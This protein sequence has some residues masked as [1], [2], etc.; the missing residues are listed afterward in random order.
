MA[1]PAA[2]FT[3]VNYTVKD[4]SA[5]AGELTGRGWV[6]QRYEGTPRDADGVMRANGPDIA[7]FTDPAGNFLSVVA[8]GRPAQPRGSRSP[9][10][11]RRSVDMR[12]RFRGELFGDVLVG[13]RVSV[14]VRRAHAG[15]DNGT[16]RSPLTGWSRYG[17]VV[18]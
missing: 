9:G 10:S 17:N 2:S 6:L 8:Q 13:V 14:R 12:V 11:P 7:W 16:M 5:A 4:V 3:I 18:R 15:T 1:S